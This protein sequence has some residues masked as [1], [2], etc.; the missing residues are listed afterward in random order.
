MK[1]KLSLVAIGFAISGNVY[2]NC[3]EIDD[4]SKRLACYDSL[5]QRGESPVDTS[6]PSAVDY[7]NRQQ[8]LE[9]DI[10]KM[11][12]R[13]LSR[14]FDEQEPFKLAPHLPNFILPASYNSKVN[15]EVWEQIEPGAEINRTE[16][17]FQISG[18]LKLLDDIYND[19]WDL[20]FGY[21][22]TAW[23]QLYNSDE[24]APFR[25]TNYSP[26]LLLRYY[27]DY[28]IFGMN[29][30]ETDIGL[31]HQ[32]NGRSEPLSRSWNRIY[33][34]FALAKG[35]FLLNLK[36][37]YRIPESEGDDDNPDIHKYMGYGDYRLSYKD[38]GSIYSIMLRNNLNF[39]DNK[40]GVE[41]NWAF[42]INDVVKVYLEYYNGYGESLIDYD[43]YTN[44]IS[45]GILIY[46][47]L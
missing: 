28:N 16:V 15:R 46:D 18:K 13:Q 42:P 6:E 45:V 23:W 4:P 20:W 38:N 5:Y 2:A 25:E 37:W 24:S 40:G 10:D 36:P 21:T 34:N 39:N 35:N 11:T 3:W 47:W 17:K 30:L 9:F 7:E 27:S 41:L 19:N 8:K 1:N 32:S 29:L 44:R 33:V 43:H 12:Y 26:E 31:L 22:Q 14:Y